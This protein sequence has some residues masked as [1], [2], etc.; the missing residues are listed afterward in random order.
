MSRET[1]A[2]KQLIDNYKT[3][4]QSKDRRVGT[5]P[6]PLRHNVVL[7]QLQELHPPPPPPRA[8]ELREWAK[9]TEMWFALFGGDLDSNC[10]CASDLLPNGKIHTRT[11][12]L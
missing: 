2:K 3:G 12:Y 11:G 4:P 10:A 1:K 5:F 6:F 9:R 7:K 8:R